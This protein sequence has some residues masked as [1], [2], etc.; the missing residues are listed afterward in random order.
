MSQ[1]LVQ[2][3][4]DKLTPQKKRDP[5]PDFTAPQ[6]QY[7]KL[8]SARLA[9]AALS[10]SVFGGLGCRGEISSMRWVKRP[11]QEMG[12]ALLKPGPASALPIEIFDAKKRPVLMPYA[13]QGL[14][15]IDGSWKQAKACG[16][17]TR[18]CLSSTA[19]PSTR[20]VPLYGPRSNA[21]PSQL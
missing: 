16:G 3:F 6:E 10:K 4:C 21:R 14:V 1:A 7:K 11:I 15:A 19:L 8:N 20:K 9:H 2:C 12:S 5:G 17:E 13:L 18:G